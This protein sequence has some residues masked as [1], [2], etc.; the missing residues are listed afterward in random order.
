MRFDIENPIDQDRLYRAVDW[1]RYRLQPFRQKRMQLLKEFVGFWYSETGADDRV[2]VN[3]LQLA[4]NVYLRQLIA[5]APSAMAT[6]RD[7]RL[8]G[9]WADWES[10]VCQGT[11][12]MGL[13]ESLRGWVFD[14]II[15]MGIMKIGVA[16]A[17]DL[18][19]D[20]YLQLAGQPFAARV[21][22]DDWVHD[23]TA[24]RID[25]CCFM[26]N[27]YR[28]PLD[29]ARESPLY[30]K[31]A[32]QRL[33]A[34]TRFAYNERGDLRTSTL[35]QSTLQWLDE[36]QEHVELWDLWLPHQGAVITVPYSESAE[37]GFSGPPLRVIRW[38][39]P[40]EGPFV[41][42]GFLDVP[43]NVMPASPAQAWMDLH[44]LCN[45]AWRKLGRQADRQKTVL[46]VAGPNTEDGERV[47]RAND[48]EAIR[49]DRPDSAREYRFGGADRDQMLFV[50]QLRSTFNV[51]SGNI[52][53]IG[54]LSPQ[55][56]TLGQ[57][58]LL[59]GST[60]AQVAE[61]QDR[62]HSGI[63]R[64][65][66]QLAFWWYKDPVRTY[67][68]TRHVAGVDIPV[69][70]PPGMR[71]PPFETLDLDIDPYSM[72]EETPQARGAKLIQL[73][74]GVILPALPMLQQ[75]GVQLKWPDL[76]ECLGKY[77][78]LPD[79]PKIIQVGPP[80]G[81]MPSAM[82]AAGAGGA[83]GEPPGKPPVTQRTHVRKNVPMMTNRGQSQVMQ[84][85]LAG[86]GNR[87]QRAMIGPA[88]VAA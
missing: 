60:S 80:P 55:S 38:E 33:Q 32:R 48:G 64:V 54:G 34:M 28:V 79:L 17:G 10:W 57:D 42:L 46:G 53:A 52:E 26:G 82:M 47:V 84:Q 27:R 31:K 36:Y 40:K 18:E 25:Q 3:L 73:L 1:S 21:D 39:G 69:L 83:P 61:M 67:Q 75:Q 66:R 49:M 43:N 45:R 65:Y 29:E 2:P 41:T 14:A 8:A 72:T 85:L 5:R 56:H 13:A 12:E 81:L 4:S 86:G 78:S 76:L 59:H 44:L 68:A 35:S 77:L 7:P 58:E 71:R 16:P 20:G 9:L 11:R 88:G 37:G 70:I 51:Q 6:T 22:L 19:I 63:A 87:Q 74:Q 50:E 62:V 23:I 30:D 15:S 24:R